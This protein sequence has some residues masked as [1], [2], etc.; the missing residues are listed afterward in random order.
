MYR[1]YNIPVVMKKYTCLII[2]IFTGSFLMGQ[3]AQIDSLKSVFENATHDTTRLEIL[4]V[5]GSKYIYIS[6]DSALS[7]NNTSIK[8]AEKNIVSANIK[9]VK[10]NTIEYVY[11]FYKAH[12][13][14]QIGNIYEYQGE[15]GKAMD[16]YNK[17][18]EMAIELKDFKL[19]T[20]S[21][22][23]M[24][25]ICDLQGFWDKA[26][27]YYQKSLDYNKEHGSKQSIAAGYGNIGIAYSNQGNYTMAMEYLIKSLEILE[28]LGEKYSLASIYNSI[29]DLQKNM[30]KPYKA[31]ESFKKG[32]ALAKEIDN[33]YLILACTGNMAIVYSDLGKNKEAM[34]HY[35]IA[36]S[37]AEELQAKDAIAE[38]YLYIGDLQNSMGE[39]DKSEESLLK[40]IKIF[41]EIEN[42]MLL[43]TSYVR[44]AKL[45]ST[46]VD[47]INK[48]TDYKNWKL[49]LTSALH[50][51][52][53]AIIVEKEI[54]SIKRQHEI[55]PVLIEINKKL[56]KDKDALKYAELFIS[57]Q[58]SMFSA[59]KTK[60]IQEMETKYE[61]D[62]KEQQIKMQDVQLKLQN[63]IKNV[64]LTG[65]ILVFVLALIIL[66]FFVQKR[67][68]N[69]I[70][71]KQKKEIKVQAE[72]LKTTNEKLNQLNKL[73]DKMFSIISH[74]LRGPLAN[75]N[76]SLGIMTNEQFENSP[77]K[78]EKMLKL[79][80]QGTQSALGLLENLLNWS[81][82]QQNTMAFS[83]ETIHISEIVEETFI[84]LQ[85]NAAS[86][87]IELKS[88]I[89]NDIR[90]FVDK[91]MIKTVIR[92]L[93]NNAIK[94]CNEKG[95]IEIFT[96]TGTN[97]IEIGIKD[98][99][100]G[101]SKENL[102]KLLNPNEHITTHGTKKEKGAGLGLI[103]CKEFIE[104]N[105]GT[106][107][108]ESKPG[109][110]STFFITLP[111]SNDCN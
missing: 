103:I 43:V 23:D 89:P 74:D 83:P 51:G 25:T 63:R 70:L 100:V 69:K 68:A 15:Y 40:A 12:A 30:L 107:R 6:L 108:V 59:D 73:K 56:G 7:I 76:T 67:K 8:I 33:K 10:K 37:I 48:S 91:N 24:G 79:L 94:F 31:M 5:L 1:I 96:K 14:Y 45:Y 53:Q 17:S 62:K 75:L 50:A 90:V 80:S 64:Y 46:I 35:Q 21:Y 3:N 36:L 39:Y 28:K 61:T 78:N 11:F 54:N 105:N 55:A 65:F 19:M 42:K 13:L 95:K 44:L 101:I 71:A 109:E 49:H 4:R 99:G 32:L 29:G 58:D 20:Q 87:L 92:N 57:L 66:W 16:Y 38:S 2:L 110:G 77:E 106:I 98:N 26:I 81:R 86:K 88:E 93:V 34:E 97:R 104:K 41:K 84:L 27:E 22:T 52:E 111:I 9:N 85:P 18:V 60:A 82:S 72:E 47:T 102:L